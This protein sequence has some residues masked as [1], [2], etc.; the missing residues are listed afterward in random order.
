M[1]DPT[2]LSLANLP[3]LS[4]RIATPRYSRQALRPGIV[5]FGVGNFHRAHQAVYLDRLMN[6]GL[7]HDF[8]I[9]GVGTRPA[10][11]AVLNALQGQDH[12][13]TVVEQSAAAS[14]ARITGAMTAMIGPDGAQRAIDALADPRTRIVTLTITEGGYYIDPTTGAFDENHPDIRADSE[15]SGAPKTVFGL[16]LAGLA[17]RWEAG[18]APFTIASCDNIPHNGSVTRAAVTGLARLQGGDLAGRVSEVAFP[19][20]MVDRITPATS[21]RERTLAQTL[22]GV[23]DNWPVFCEDYTQWVIEDD[24]PA[25]RPPLE[26]VGV[27]FVADV[28]G[29]EAMKIRILNGSHAILA[30]PAALL[31]ID[32][33]HDAMADPT[34]STFLDKVVRDEVLPFV[35][36]VPGVDLPQY[37]THTKTRI[38]NPKVA[39]TVR[40]LCHDGSNRQPKF[41]VPT[42]RDA[43]ADGH[44]V[45]GL[46]LASALWCRYCCGTTETGAQ[47]APNDPQWDGLNGLARQAMDAPQIWLEQGQIYGDLAH[48]PAFAGPFAASLATIRDSGVRS[49]IDAYLRR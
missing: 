18:V 8:A 14:T 25:G 43:V 27:E 31:G 41:I 2:P 10:D 48:S 35:A 6:K 4:G 5:H 13:T 22:F 45:R 1:S 21:Q 19:N 26:D 20:S 38:A 40:R 3:A 29:H 23:A 28:S 12:L 34:V 16:I 17:R 32:F 37:F 7:A 49:A 42:L 39:D 11:N 9:V 46:A 33:V 24:F 15:G 30:Y 36:D 47:I 44:A